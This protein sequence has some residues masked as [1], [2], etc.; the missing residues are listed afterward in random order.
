[1]ILLSL[2]QEAVQLILPVTGITCTVSDQDTFI[3]QLCAD[4]FC[5]HLRR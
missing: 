5:D 3:E 1:M 4:N 2:S